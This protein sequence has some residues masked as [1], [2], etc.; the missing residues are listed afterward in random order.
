MSKFV[1]AGVNVIKFGLVGI[2]TKDAC[3][4]SSSKTKPDFATAFFFSLFSN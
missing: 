4:E 3:D 2:C 1:L